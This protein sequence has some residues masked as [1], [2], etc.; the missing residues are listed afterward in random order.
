MKTMNAKKM[1]FDFSAVN[2][3]QRNV[4]SEPQVI[5]TSTAGGFRVT[6]PVTKVLGI[7]AGEY[8]QFVNNVDSIDAAIR[9]K[10][11]VIVAFCDENGL[12]ITTPQALVAI[13][14][15]FDTWGIVKGVAALDQHGNARTCQERLTKA[16]KIKYV[17]ADFDDSLAAA[18]DEN[19]GIADDVRE[20]LTRDGVTK[21]EQ[22]AILSQFVSAREL[23]KF[24]GSKTANSANLTGV[25][26][27]LNFTDANVWKQLKADLGDN[28][29]K[30][31]RVFSIDLDEITT[32]VIDNG[33]EKIE[34]PML[35]LGEYKDEDPMVRESKKEVAE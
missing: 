25:G 17:E 7:S 35:V 10:H 26:T 31:N 18:L 14:K 29:V 1:S 32:A 8:I 27:T 28:D 11:E 21:E 23:P 12:D 2:A 16:D 33:Y 20:S 5:A 6:G 3:G 30:K 4:A 24:L 15:E 19:S 34:V 22:V 13:H 9:S